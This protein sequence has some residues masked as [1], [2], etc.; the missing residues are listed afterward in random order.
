MTRGN[1]D[2]R[3]FLQSATLVATAATAATGA[4]A[5][6]TPSAAEKAPRRTRTCRDGG[7]RRA[8]SRYPIGR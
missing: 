5:A 1:V 2:R 7:D 3:R 4:L 6:D 8:C